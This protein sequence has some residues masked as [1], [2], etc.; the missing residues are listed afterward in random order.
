MSPIE[1]T[2]SASCVLLGSCGALST[3]KSIKAA[4]SHFSPTETEVSLFP[5]RLQLGLITPTG[6]DMM[7][8]SLLAI[9]CRLIYTCINVRRP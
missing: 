7:Q 9:I 4:T 3:K 8:N 2:T 6:Q 5:E 1:P